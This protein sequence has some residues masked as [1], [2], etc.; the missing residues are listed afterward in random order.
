MK[1]L[2]RKAQLMR[3]QLARIHIPQPTLIGADHQQ[4]AILVMQMLGCGQVGHGPDLSAMAFIGFRLSKI[5]DDHARRGHAVAKTIVI[6]VGHIPDGNARIVQPHT[7]QIPVRALRQ[8]AA[9][10][11]VF[12]FPWIAI[13][14]GGQ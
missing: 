8:F 13:Q 12:G 10:G 2:G 1:T 7:G 5:E 11:A 9:R 14:P 3:Q 6:P 4:L